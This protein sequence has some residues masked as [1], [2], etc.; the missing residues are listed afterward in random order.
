MHQD[1][2]VQMVAA[3]ELLTADEAL[4]VAVVVVDALVALELIGAGEALAAGGQVAHVGTIVVVGA[5]VGTQVRSLVVL[6]GTL[7]TAVGALLALV[8]GALT[9]RVLLPAEVKQRLE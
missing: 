4:E 1:V 7:V 9:V 6:F 5:Q 2:L 3:Q 8:R